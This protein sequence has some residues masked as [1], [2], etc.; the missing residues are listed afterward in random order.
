MQLNLDVVLVLAVLGADTLGAAGSVEL[1]FTPEAVTTR[2]KK[3][4]VSCLV[5][6]TYTSLFEKKKEK[7]KKELTR[8]RSGGRWSCCTCWRRCRPR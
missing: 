7:K 2:T 5:R 1:D 3:Q 6:N 4:W 8:E